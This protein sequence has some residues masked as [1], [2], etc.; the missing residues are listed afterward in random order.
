MSEEEETDEKSEDDED[1]SEESEEEGQKDSDLEKRIKKIKEYGIDDGEVFAK[2]RNGNYSV[3]NELP[4]LG[5]HAFLSLINDGYVRKNNEE[6][7]KKD[8]TGK[9]VKVLVLGTLEG[10]DNGAEFVKACKRT[11][12]DCYVITIDYSKPIEEIAEEVSEKIRAI[13]EQTNALSVVAH[14]FSLGGSALFYAT[15][16]TDLEQDVSEAVYINT[17][18]SGERTLSTRIIQF[19]GGTKVKENARAI[20]EATNLGY[21]RVPSVFVYSSG[22]TIVPSGSNSSVARILGSRTIQIEGGR[23]TT[24]MD[25]PDALVGTLYK[26]A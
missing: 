2:L 8:Y 19:L 25:S 24:I 6:I 17:P 12:K 1:K 9:K 23:H 5:V 22:D 7:V 10:E 3:L 15:Q 20:R 11:G 4:D 13:K 14:G 16:M 21:T 18:L 26:A